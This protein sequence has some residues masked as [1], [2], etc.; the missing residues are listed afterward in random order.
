MRFEQLGR[1][2]RVA[3]AAAVVS[4]LAVRPRDGARV[5]IREAMVK[6]IP[7]GAAPAAARTARP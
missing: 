5:T 1:K 2:L 4:T 6:A 3:A 7:D